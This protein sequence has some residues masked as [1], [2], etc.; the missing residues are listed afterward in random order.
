MTLIYDSLETG[1]QHEW[2]RE[3]MPRLPAAGVCKYL[4][5]SGFEL[6]ATPACHSSLLCVS[7]CF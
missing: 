2:I 5:S 7:L 3:L 1:K 4:L 6:K